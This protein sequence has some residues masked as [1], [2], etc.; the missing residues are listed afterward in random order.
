[1]PIGQFL[2]SFPAALFIAAHVAF[3]GVG[4]YCI[5]QIKALQPGLTL[6]LWLYPI[7]Q[8]GFLVFFAGASTLKLAVLVEQMLMVAL[9]VLVARKPGTMQQG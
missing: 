9:V 6:A 5:K 3:I 2:D 7:S 4:L 8:I 1:M